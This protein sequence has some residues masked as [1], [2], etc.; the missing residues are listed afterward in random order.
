[1]KVT[2]YSTLI[3]GK[4]GKPEEV[5]PG[6]PVN[7]DDDEAR[8]LI[9]RGIVVKVGKAAAAPVEPPAETPPADPEAG[10]QP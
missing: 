1:M 2:S 7:L 4:A 8:D 6:T 10:K 5:P 3:V 9:E